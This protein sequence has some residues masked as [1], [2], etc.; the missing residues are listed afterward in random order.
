MYHH[1]TNKTIYDSYRGAKSMPLSPQIRQELGLLANMKTGRRTL[2]AF[3][4]IRWVDASGEC[5]GVFFK[6]HMITHCV[7]F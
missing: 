7:K 5:R 3:F 4:R 6:F 2:I 1:E